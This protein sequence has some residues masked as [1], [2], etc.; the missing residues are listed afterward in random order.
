M[1]NPE[2]T[3]APLELLLLLPCRAVGGDSFQELNEVDVVLGDDGIADLSLV[4]S[5]GRPHRGVL[6]TQAGEVFKGR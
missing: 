4:E 6:V 5:V 3:L 1:L 2:Q